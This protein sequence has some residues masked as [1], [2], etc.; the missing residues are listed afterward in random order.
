MVYK[1][2]LRA[3]GG[4]LSFTASPIAGDRHLFLTA[5]DGRVLVIKAGSDFKLEEVN[6]LGESILATPAVSR[7]A[8]FFRTQN[9][10]IAV[11]KH[12]PP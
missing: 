1:Q 5:E 8:M 6:Q 11:G 3:K 2:R 12:L 9:S 7:G 4:T 10:L